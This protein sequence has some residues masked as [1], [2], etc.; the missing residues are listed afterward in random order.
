MDSKQF[1][2]QRIENFRKSKKSEV[3]WESEESKKSNPKQS[4]ELEASENF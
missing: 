2:E 4:N 3:Y 1:N